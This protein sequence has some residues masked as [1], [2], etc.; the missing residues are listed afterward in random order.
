L[1][2]YSGPPVGVLYEGPWWA[3]PLLGDACSTL[4]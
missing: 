2:H 4:R 1:L 3:S